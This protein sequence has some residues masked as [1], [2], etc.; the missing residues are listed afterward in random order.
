[1]TD[2]ALPLAGVPFAVKDQSALVGE[3]LSRGSRAPAPVQEADEPLVARLRAAGAI[4]VGITNVPELMIFPWTATAANGITR[5]P[6][7]PVAHA[8]WAPRAARRL[9]WPPVWSRLP[10]RAT[11]AARSGSRRPAAGCPGSRP[12]RGLVATDEGWLGMSVTGTLSR[13]VA[14]TGLLLDLTHG[15]GATRP[16]SGSPGPP[17]PRLPRPLRIALSAQ[18]A[19]RRRSRPGRGRA[20][21]GARAHGPSCLSHS[22]TT[23]ANAIRRPSER[24][25]SEFLQLWTRGVYEDSLSISDRSLLERSTRQMAAIGRYAV[26]RWRRRSAAQRTRAA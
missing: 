5:N 2:R 12:S 8:R 6:W 21:R 19:A 7:D 9:P 24:R 16:L 1:M 11:A 4:P 14:D 13:T 17:R 22:A 10:P 23:S 25:E 26:P 18:G 15:A 3:T 20:A